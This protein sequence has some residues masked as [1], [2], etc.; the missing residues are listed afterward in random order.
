MFAHLICPWHVAMVT[1]HGYVEMSVFM[2]SQLLKVKHVNL[3][4]SP[5]SVE[6]QVWARLF[7]LSKWDLDLDLDLGLDLEEA[8]LDPFSA[9]SEPARSALYYSCGG[10]HTTQPLIWLLQ[11]L[12]SAGLIKQFGRQRPVT[13]SPAS[14]QS[15]HTSFWLGGGEI[16]LLSLA[17]GAFPSWG[18]S[19]SERRRPTA[20]WEMRPR[21]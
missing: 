14:S 3:S 19:L 20:F 9:Y 10:M 21:S 16:P 12:L 6:G 11:P 8:A 15:L 18:A 7:T 2:E 17:L 1:V 4:H 5:T 13:P